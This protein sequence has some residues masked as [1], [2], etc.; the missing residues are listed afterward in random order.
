MQTQWRYAGGGMGPAL[1]SGLDYAGV[2]AWLGAQGYRTHPRKGQAS[3]GRIL[4]DLRECEAVAL[5]EWHAQAARESRKG[6]G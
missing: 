5:H 1:H 4:D 3:M 6:R 2:C